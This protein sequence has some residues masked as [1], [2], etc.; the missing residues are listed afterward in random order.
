MTVKIYGI[1]N[2]NTMK[3]A[4]HLLEQEGVGYDFIDYKKER[5]DNELLGSFMKKKGLEELINKR[6]TTYKK[7]S[8]EQKEFLGDE[9]TAVPIIIENSSMIKRPIIE[10]PDGELIVGLQEEEIVKKARSK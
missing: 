8:D 3:R 4:F 6:G 2:C 5:P 7:L 1:K 10:F 9:A